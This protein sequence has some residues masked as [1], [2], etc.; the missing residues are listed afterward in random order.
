M[1]EVANGSVGRYVMCGLKERLRRVR[2]GNKCQ[3]ELGRFRM[4]LNEKSKK[5]RFGYEGSS[6]C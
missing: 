5:R 3:I 6:V 2:L 1:E 4:K